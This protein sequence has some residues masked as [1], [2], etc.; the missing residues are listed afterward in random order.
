MWPY[1]GCHAMKPTSWVRR[2]TNPLI[3]RLS[4]GLPA[5]SFDHGGNNTA[6]V[7]RNA[8]AAMPAALKG[9][10]KAAGCLPLPAPVP[11][12]QCRTRYATP[13]QGQRHGG[14][15]LPEPT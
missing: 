7:L 13:W 6:G 15:P 14:L 5:L 3:R 8:A 1:V 12:L 11:A 4:T 2:L 9:D 10:L